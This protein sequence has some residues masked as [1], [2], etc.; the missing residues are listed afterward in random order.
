MACLFSSSIGCRLNRTILFLLFTSDLHMY[1]YQRPEPCALGCRCRN[2]F[3]QIIKHFASKI[4]LEILSFQIYW[5]R[6]GDLEPKFLRMIFY[7]AFTMVLLCVCGNLYIHN[8]GKT[9]WPIRGGLAKKPHQSLVTKASLWYCLVCCDLF[10]TYKMFAD[11]NQW[12]SVL[13]NSMD[14]VNTYMQQWWKHSNF[15]MLN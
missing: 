9:K 12:S 10:F 15:L 13:V 5:Y 7:N 6:Q 3:C 11:V 8:V 14:I 4:I 1:K 2:I